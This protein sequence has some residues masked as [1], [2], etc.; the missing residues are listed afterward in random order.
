MKLSSDGSCI[1]WN[2]PPVKLPSN[3]SLCQWTILR[4]V[5]VPSETNLRWVSVSSELVSDGSV[6]SE[7]T[8]LS[9]QR[10]CLRWVLA[11]WILLRWV[12][13]SSETS[14]LG[15]YFTGSVPCWVCSQTS[16]SGLCLVSPPVGRYQSLLWNI[17]TDSS[18]TFLYQLFLCIYLPIFLSLY[19]N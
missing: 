12:L 5:S 14:P 18:V 9:L 10:F 11:Q 6:S 3:G 8:L 19:S 2:S 7:T 4:W 16:L 15:L 1:Q 13:V 17:H